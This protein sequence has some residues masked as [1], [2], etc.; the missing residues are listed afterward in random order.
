MSDLFK[1]AFEYFSGPA[2]GQQSDNNFVGQT[3]EISNVKLR[4]KKVLAEG[5]YF[6]I[7]IFNWFVSSTYNFRW[8]CCSFYRTRYKYWKRL[9]I[10]SKILMFYPSEF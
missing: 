2:Y 8:I 7:L 10:K 1:S 6:F 4:I 3:V 9:C 5:E